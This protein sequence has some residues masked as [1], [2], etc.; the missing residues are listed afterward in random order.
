MDLDGP[1]TPKRQQRRQANQTSTNNSSTAHPIRPVFENAPAGGPYQ[2]KI[3]WRNQLAAWIDEEPLPDWFRPLYES[4]S[5]ARSA[6]P[7]GYRDWDWDDAGG[8][9]ALI[10]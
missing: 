9:R 2:D 1:S 5:A 8:R 10:P 4:V 3:A 6:D 7:T